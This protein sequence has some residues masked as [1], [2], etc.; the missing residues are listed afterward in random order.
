MLFQIASGMGGAGGAI[1]AVA[2]QDAMTPRY[3]GQARSAFAGGGIECKQEELPSALH[4]R[5]KD[6]GWQEAWDVKTL[7]SDA[8]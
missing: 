4:G 7:H 1:G 5:H 6:P 8:Q 2:G 3:Q